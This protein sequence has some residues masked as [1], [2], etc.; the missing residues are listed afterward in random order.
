MG[1]YL[2]I[3]SDSFESVLKTDYVDKTGLIA[4]VNST[5]GT[6]RK[7]TCVSRPRRFGKTY[8][9]NMLAA[10][11][12]KG[13]DTRKLFQG[14][15][16]EQN[17]DFEK[18]INQYHVISLDMSTFLSQAKEKSNLI[19]IME[20]DII[21]DLAE[22][23]PN[24]REETKLLDALVRIRMEYNEKFIF[25]I[26]EW[27]AIFREWKDE[28]RQQEQY[29]EFL[30]GLFKSSQTDRICEAAYMT[31]ILPIKKYG[32]QSAVSDFYEFTMVTPEPLQQ[33]FGFTQD[34]VK[35]LCEKKQLLLGE[36]RDWYDGYQLGKEHIYNPKSVIECIY[37]EKIANYW[38]KTETYET[39][40][41]YIDLNFDGLKTA[42]IDMLGGACI[43]IDTES[44]Q[45]DMTSF[46]SR[47]DVFTLLVHLGYLAYDS[48]SRTVRIPNHEVRE[49]FIRALKNCN[50]KE[51]VKTIELSD[52]L[53]NATWNMD[54]EK[55]AAIIDEIHTKEKPHEFY[56]NEQALRSVIKMAYLSAADYYRKL[57]E[58]QAGKGYADIFFLPNRTCDKPLLIVEMKWNKTSSAAIAQI[59][60]K[61]YVKA[62]QGWDGET[63]LVGISYDTKTRRHTCKI[64]KIDSED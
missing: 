33:Y 55:V 63:L 41:L 9:L 21:A 37:R 43:K 2:D 20:Q 61:D 45:N 42:I 29:V 48:D 53:L 34:E 25:I 11:Y 38:T 46:A 52:E 7:L 17:S 16:I 22:T 13:Q 49:E 1:K 40:R 23:F 36:I 5:L 19:S 44:F 39:L 12:G 31:G 18:Y 62:I 30:R 24:V 54:G 56:N 8:A 60:E 26:D 32:H 27:D 14:L 59:K 4:Y 64:E 15:E 28:T 6:K 10:Y 35:Q 47:D 3:G 51:I 50:R 57:E 58:L